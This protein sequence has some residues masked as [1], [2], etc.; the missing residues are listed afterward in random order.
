MLNEMVPPVVIG[1][2]PLLSGAQ[3]SQFRK[4][5]HLR[6]RSVFSPDA[7]RELAMYCAESHPS[8]P[9]KQI[10]EGEPERGFFQRSTFIQQLV[11]D[12]S[13]GQ[14]AAELLGARGTRLIHD[15][16][17]VKDG[18]A[19]GTPWHRDSDF[20]SF[21]GKGALTMWIPLQPTPAHMALRYIPGSHRE[22]RRLLRRFEKGLLT[23]HKR[24]AT[25]ELD[26]GDIAIHDY[27]TLHSSARYNNGGL[28]RALALH[29]LDADARIAA[30]QTRYHKQHNESCGWN[31]LEPGESFPDE[32]A[33]LLY[34][35]NDATLT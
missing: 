17:F 8:V 13:L 10:I 22:D 18:T 34:C 3:I 14:L 9:L 15:A 6:L 32:I 5:G 1:P 35:R 25:S 11:S 21:A 29:I 26:M 20:W 28:R 2:R 4:A 30:P 27:G 23:T 24:I 31:L 19:K 12:H 16:L 7:L 33:P